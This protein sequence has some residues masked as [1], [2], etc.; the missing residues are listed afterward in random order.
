MKIKKFLR[1]GEAYFRKIEGKVLKEFIKKQ[2][3]VIATGG[4]II[5][6]IKMS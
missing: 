3:S 4:G 1:K 5:I 2:N 6:K